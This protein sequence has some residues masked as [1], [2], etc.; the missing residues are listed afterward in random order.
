MKIRILGVAIIAMASIAAFQLTLR[1]QQTA[2]R[3]ATPAALS[4]HAPRSVWDSV[5]TAEQAKRGEGFYQKTCSKCHQESLTGGDDAPPLSGT[6]FMSNWV[7]LSVGELHDKIRVSM[8]PDAAEALPR[9]TITDVVAYLLSFNGFPAG[10]TELP[11]AAEQ[12]KEI[13]IEARKP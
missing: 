9:Q 5:Y 10:K 3:G 4:R 1:A 11:L 13:R 8:P 7:G 2:P 6:P 12:L